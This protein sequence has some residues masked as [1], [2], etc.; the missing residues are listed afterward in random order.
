MT[1][2]RCCGTRQR[3]GTGHLYL[4]DLRTGRLKNRH[5]VR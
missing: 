2:T 3:D 5:H 1:A 4:Y